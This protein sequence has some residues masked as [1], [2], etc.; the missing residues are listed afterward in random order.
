LGREV[1]WESAAQAFVR[2]FEAQLEL[3]LEAGE[4]TSSE[5]SHAEELVGKKYAHPS[6]TE[7][8]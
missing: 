6:W 3:N 1:T 2:A 8:I 4:L 7:R 5:L